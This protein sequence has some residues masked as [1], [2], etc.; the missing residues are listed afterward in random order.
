MSGSPTVGQAGFGLYIDMA[1]YETGFDRAE[2]IAKTGVDRIGG[3]LRTGLSIGLGVSSFNAALVGVRR[4][5]DLAA[6]GVIG[7]N[8]AMDDAEATFGAFLGSTAAVQDKLASLFDFAKRTPFTFAGVEAASITLENLSQGVL[9]TDKYLYL[10]GDAAAAVQ[11][12]AGG[13]E[14]SLEQTAQL[15]GRLFAVL[16]TGSGNV[17]RLILRMQQLGLIAPQTAAR[18]QLLISQKASPDAIFKVYTDGLQRFSG[19]LDELEQNLSTRLATFRDNVLQFT[20]RTGKALYDAYSDALAFGNSLFNSA[21]VKAFGDVLEQRIGQAVKRVR[22]YFQDPTVQDALKA[23]LATGVQTFTSLAAVAKGFGDALVSIAVPAG[24][25]LG[26]LN[27]L[28]GNN[29]VVFTVLA[30]GAIRYRDVLTNL[31][32]IATGQINIFQR[33]NDGSKNLLVTQDRLA[34]AQKRNSDLSRN[35]TAAATAEA[36]ATDRLNAAQ[37]R[38]DQAGRRTAGLENSLQRTGFHAD[39]A[40]SNRDALSAQVDDIRARRDAQRQIIANLG[41]DQAAIGLSKEYTAALRQQQ[42]A[43]QQ[44]TNAYVVSYEAQT[45]ANQATDARIAAVN[46]LRTAELALAQAERESLTSSSQVSASRDE[47]QTIAN[48]RRSQQRE[49]SAAQG[50]VTTANRSIAQIDF[51][52]QQGV[53]DPEK[54]AASRARAVAQL[55]LRE[56]QLAKAEAGLVET[57]NAEREAQDALNGVLSHQAQLDATVAASTDAVGAARA[58]VTALVRAETKAQ[59]DLT[60]AREREVAAE[61][62]VLELQAA[63][64]GERLAARNALIQEAALTQELTVAERA[65][66]AA[67][68]EV[69]SVT[70]T[71]SSLSGRLVAA[72]EA[73]ITATEAAARAERDLNAARDKAALSNAKAEAG[74]ASLTGAFGK[75]SAGIGIAVTA[76]IALSAA[77]EAATGQGITQNISDLATYGNLYAGLAKKI[78]DADLAIANGDKKVYDQQVAQHQQ[79]IAQLEQEEAQIIALQKRGPLSNPAAFADFVKL[80]AQN[81]FNPFFS[82]K[83]ATDLAAQKKAVEDAQKAWEDYQAQVQATADFEN[84]LK[85]GTF[86]GPLTEAQRGK[87]KELLDQAAK[88]TAKLLGVSVDDVSDETLKKLQGEGEALL[89]VGETNVNKYLEGFTSGDVGI[90]TELI[91]QV[92]ANLREGLSSSDLGLEDL[93]KIQKVFPLFQEAIH[94]VREYG[95]V[96]EEVFTQIDQVLGGDTENVNKLIRA[97]LNLVAAQHE[98]A[99]AQNQVNAAQSILTEIQKRAKAGDPNIIR[100]TQNDTQPPPPSVRTGAPRAEVDSYVAITQ[101]QRIAAEGL[102]K[103]QSDLDAAQEKAKQ[104]AKDLAEALRPFQAALKETERLAKLSA[105]SN[106]DSVKEQQ[107]VVSQLQRQQSDAQRERAA[108]LAAIQD[109]LTAAQKHGT[110]LQNIAS[111]HQ[112][113]YNAILNDTLQYYLQENDVLDDTT[114][115]IIERWNAELSGLTRLRNATQQRAD[116]G[117]KQQRADILAFN[118]AIEK[119]RQRGD[120]GQVNALTHQR[121]LYEKTSSRQLDLEHQRAQVAADRLDTAADKLKKEAAQQDAVDQA[122]VNRNTRDQQ[123]IQARIDLQSKYNAAQDEADRK[124]LQAAQDELAARQ[125]K[126]DDDARY[127]QDR[128]DSDQQHIDDLQTAG[129]SQA[130]IDQKAIDDTQTRYDI[131][132][133]YWD[134]ELTTAQLSLDAANARLAAANEYYKIIDESLT[135]LKDQKGVINDMKGLLDQIIDVLRQAFPNNPNFQPPKPG[136]GSE[137]NPADVGLPANPGGTYPNTNPATQPAGQPGGQ[138]P[139]SGSTTSTAPQY[140]SAGGPSLPILPGDQTIP[141]PPGYH[142]ET[143]DSSFLWEVPDG[144]HLENYGRKQGAAPSSGGGGANYSKVSAF[145]SGVVAPVP[146][147]PVAGLTAYSL[148]G[149]GGGISAA[150]LAPSLPGSASGLLPAMLQLAGG[151]D[152]IAKAGLV[153]DGG[154]LAYKHEGP[155]IGTAIIREEADIGKLA[156]AI[157]I[158]QLAAFKQERRRGI[159][160]GRNNA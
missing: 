61:A 127:W 64:Q 8:Q 36:D 95:A 9:D 57:L 45:K 27:K 26:L 92:K 80:T 43:Q 66:E 159:A 144:F 82:V 135:V 1:E 151:I 108:G 143:D 126:A 46:R 155:L 18:M 28:S 77:S 87:Q 89:K 94:Q 118:E 99:D 136:P 70:A 119:A 15:S 85:A 91:D 158:A 41:G 10:F 100:A 76:L 44:L 67:K 128:Q 4:A 2:R 56:N 110:D 134:G 83:I 104:H 102:D 154:A 53:G 81:N 50:R 54:L 48:L 160:H 68:A 88:D 109:E 90:L 72:R 152:G 103:L 86:I 113:A 69:A 20:G 132:K 51:F 40:A 139:G 130:L 11:Q 84:Q 55:E 73:E 129:D 116:T 24:Q 121:D 60:T 14:K 106:Q 22:E 12:A 7:F 62:R 75:V 115:K 74:T 148:A 147:A 153:G 19:T 105:R 79:R 16:E 101:E 21:Q 114:K 149:I 112:A 29:L 142:K 140:G 98:V 96:G 120:V 32:G 39:A 78:N 34:A 5:L 42:G 58:E 150:G 47:L 37:R 145:G 124:A 30:A 157:S 125:K 49:V 31:I 25:I 63:T 65:L 131:A 93:I 141:S 3:V 117:D 59:L 13:M 156:H 35:A 111:E 137:T 123:A 6:E 23:W 17:A 138:P 107:D 133:K 38:L 122:A 33:L 71:Q 52:A 97:Y 146:T